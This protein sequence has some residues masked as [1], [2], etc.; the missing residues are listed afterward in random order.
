MSRTGRIH[1]HVPGHMTDPAGEELPKFY[2]LLIAE[3]QA[4]GA[5]TAVVHRDLEHLAHGDLAP[6]FHFVH[7][8]RIERPRL[9]NTGLAYLYPF[10][11]MDPTGIHADS[12]L[13]KAPFVASDTP[14][15]QRFA[16]RLARRLVASRTSRYSQPDHR[17][18][19]PAGSIAV[20]LQGWSD[21]VAR[22][23]HMDSRA[24]L[25]AVLADTGGYPVVVKPH[26]QNHDAETAEALHWLTRHHPAVI[27]TRANVHD[28][29][30][31][32]AL[33]VTI[34]SAVALEAMLHRVPSVL[35]GRTDFH[36]CA[37]TVRTA[38]GWPAARDRALATPYP[39]AGF[40]H[41]FLGNG[42]INAGRGDMIGEVV[43]RMAAQGCDIAALSPPG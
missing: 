9:L 5:A 31:S 19:F 43:R 24:M 27:Q 10:W 41:W 32:A 1:F 3:F 40:L 26:P 16:D 6:G 20:F 39:F 17:E 42:M 8:G 4:R 23:R 12:T 36:H 25:A 22:V 37:E 18:T 29:L 38:A 33:C 7:N 2:R 15:A 13:T 30:A 28:I 14:G 35:F 21:P 34:S 11:Y